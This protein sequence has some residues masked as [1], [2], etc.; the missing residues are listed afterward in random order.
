VRVVIADYDPHWPKLFQL[1][2]DR[3]LAALGSGALLIEHAGST[4]VPGLAAKPVIDMVLA[5]ANSAEEDAYVP[6]LESAGYVL[7]IREPLWFEHRMFKGPGTETNLHVFSAGCSEIDRTLLF[8]DWLRSN[9]A[10]RD[11]YQRAK[12]ELAGQEWEHIQ[13][14]ADAKTAVIGEIME[15][16]RAFRS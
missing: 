12:I 3:V 4:S 9:P 5:V 15:R 6:A 16:A 2:A 1:E 10:D 8:R 11:L 13:N 14:Y 7:R